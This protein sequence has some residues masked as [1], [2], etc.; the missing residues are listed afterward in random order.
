MAAI[1]QNKKTWQP[2]VR[3]QA[4]GAA[5][6][7]ARIRVWDNDGD[8]VVNELTLAT[9]KI[10]VENLFQE[11]LEVTGVDTVV[12][13]PET[14]HQV[15]TIYIGDVQ[16]D[17]GL[18]ACY[19]NQFDKDLEGVAS[20]NT[21]FLRI[22]QFIA[23]SKTTID[24][25]TGL[26]FDH[27]VGFEKLTLGAGTIDT[28]LEIYEKC[29]ANNFNDARYAIE[30]PLTTI[31]GN[32]YQVF[33]DLD[34][35]AV[36]LVGGGN[37]LSM[38]GSKELSFLTTGTFSGALTVNGNINWGTVTDVSNLNCPGTF[39]FTTAGTYTF[40]DCTINEVTNSSGG[41]VT[42]SPVN[43]T[44]AINTGPNITILQPQR[45]FTFTLSPSI[46]AYEW[47][48]YEV[49]ALGSMAGAVEVDGEESATVDNQTYNYGYSVDQPIAVQ[50]LPQPDSDYEESITY[51]NL[52]DANQSV[53]I[54]LTPDINN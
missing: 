28:I 9:G 44:F 54:N 45:S 46:T 51:Y 41:A 5:V 17:T 42:I 31:D 19:T 52:I 22:D 30:Q 39:D 23:N 48:I 25:Y 13:Y 4:T 2:T 26:T 7:G 36:T 6:E 37:T 3:L 12:A 47:R 34:I 49:T 50:I 15:R 24:G 20:L 1:V 8:D 33:Y 10:A 40:T 11:Y 29:V 35:N 38:V 16:I 14:P 21:I 53:T 32:T 27:T 43:S 18:Y